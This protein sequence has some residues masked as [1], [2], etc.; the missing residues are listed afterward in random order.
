[1]ASWGEMMAKGIYIFKG[2][3]FTCSR[4][5]TSIFIVGYEAYAKQAIKE[6]MGFAY[7][8]VVG[9]TDSHD[10]FIKVVPAL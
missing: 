10:K 1:M 3:V 6:E 2:Y 7:S 5:N 9:H 4:Y 8:H